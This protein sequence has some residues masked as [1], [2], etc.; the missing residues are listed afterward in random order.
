MIFKT[1]K[2]WKMEYAHREVMFSTSCYERC[3]MFSHKYLNRIRYF[4]LI[5]K[6]ID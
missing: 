1:Q 3:Y 2:E 6:Y 4:P 5:R